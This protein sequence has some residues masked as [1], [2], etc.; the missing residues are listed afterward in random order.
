MKNVVLFHGTGGRPDLFWFPWLRVKLERNG[1][2]VWA[3]QLPDAER[4]DIAVWL[5]FALEN[6]TYSNETILVGHSAGGPLILGV[7]ESLNV[8]VD[9]AILVAGYA[10]MLKQNEPLPILKASYDWERIRARCKNFV[11]INSDDDPWGCDDKKGRYMFDRLGG[12]LIIPHG[13][14]HMG[15]LS[16]NQPYSTFPLLWAFINCDI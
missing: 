12:T 13:Q 5:P 2:P 7:L 15:S 6:G 4:A 3:P 16:Y 1:I 8:V 9:R 11:F 14:G 10:E